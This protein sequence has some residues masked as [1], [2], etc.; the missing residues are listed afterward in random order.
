MIYGVSHGTS[1][2]IESIIDS[3][4]LSG[5]AE[6]KLLIVNLDLIWTYLGNRGRLAII[7]NFQSLSSIDF[8]LNI[9]LLNSPRFSAERLGFGN[10]FETLNKST[11]ECLIR[12]IFQPLDFISRQRGSLEKPA[13]Y[14][15]CD[16]TNSIS[17]SM[18]SH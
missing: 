18:L 3:W 5:T 2:L 9:K 13:F 11:L 10:P 14:S 15:A 8:D 16:I 12:K 17:L 1:M 6:S 7:P 4:I